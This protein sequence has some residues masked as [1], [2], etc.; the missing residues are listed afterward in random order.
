MTH[1]LPDDPLEI[2]LTRRKKEVKKE[3]IK[4]HARKIRSN[5]WNYCGRSLHCYD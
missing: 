2:N 1:R 5:F 3:L 4:M